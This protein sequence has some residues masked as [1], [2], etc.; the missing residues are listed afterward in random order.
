V[1]RDSRVVTW[2]SKQVSFNADLI[3]DL[4]EGESEYS[5]FC[6]TPPEVWLLTTLL[7]FYGEFPKRFEGFDTQLDID[8]LRGTS[9]RGLI[10]PVACSEDV[11]R[12]ATALETMA[13]SL[14][15][16]NVKLGPGGSDLDQRLEDI[17]TSLDAIETKL[18]SSTLF[19]EI[20]TVLDN[21]AVILGAPSEDPVPVP[22]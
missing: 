17:D 22:P 8:D 18:P 2:K 11:E 12:I 1:T 15:E 4:T 10:N 5:F 16:I 19:D 21:T 3:A 20:E 13:I 9:L 7:E 14:E 6:L